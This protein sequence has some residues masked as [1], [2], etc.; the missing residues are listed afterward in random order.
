MTDEERL[1]LFLYILRR[2]HKIGAG[3]MIRICREHVQKA[4]EA[5]GTKYDDEQGGEFCLKM[6]GAILGR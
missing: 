2:D 1:A 6:A 4:A 5:G 3:D